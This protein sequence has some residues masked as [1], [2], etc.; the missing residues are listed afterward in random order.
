MAT[1]VRAWRNRLQPF[2]DVAIAAAVLLLSLLPLLSAGDC[3][4]EEIPAWGFA[5]VV[6]QSVALV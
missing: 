6:A 5:L 1:D 2:A 3:G 4:C